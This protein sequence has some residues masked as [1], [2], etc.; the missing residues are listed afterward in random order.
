[1]SK[2]TLTNLLEDEK[3]ELQLQAAPALDGRSDATDTV[4]DLDFRGFQVHTVKL[5]VESSTSVDV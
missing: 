5:T 3:E 4:V 1:M 2:V